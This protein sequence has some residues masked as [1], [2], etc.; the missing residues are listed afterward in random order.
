MEELIQKIML[1]AYQL[2][3]QTKAD[4]FID[5]QAHVNH[6]NITYY[7]DGWR[8]DREKVVRKYIDLKL[9]KFSIR[10]LE[11]TLKE[12]EALEEK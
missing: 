3:T 11:D 1:K 8:A 6:L 4:V 12:L 2:S 7:I 5:Y 9:G 10:D